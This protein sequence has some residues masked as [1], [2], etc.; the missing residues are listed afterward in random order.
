MLN[1]QQRI[2]LT[3]VSPF[4]GRV[5]EQQPEAIQTADDGM[6]QLCAPQNYRQ[7]IDERL[8]SVDDENRAQQELRLQRN[9]WFAALAAADLLGQLTLQQM[10]AHLTAA[11]DAFISASLAWLYPRFTSRHGTPLNADGQEQQLLVI[12]MGK[13]GGG[14]LNF[15]SDIDLIF[16][17][18]EQGETDHSRKPI[19]NGVF[20]TRLGQ[21]LVGLL[22]APTG[23][24]RVFRVDL[25]LRPFGQS[26]PLVA[27][28][29]ALEYYYQEQGRD[30]E[31]YAMVKARMIGA[32][33]AWQEELRSLLRPFVYRRYIDFSAIDAL[34]KMKSLITQETRRQGVRNNI[35]LGPGGI[36]E[37]EFIAQAFQL[38]RGGQERQ[39]QTQS[40][41][42]AY[43]AIRDLNLLAPAAVTELLSCYEH[44]RK[45]EHVLQQINDEQTQTLPDDKE[46]QQ[47]I[48]RVFDQ[49]WEQITADIATSMNKV[50]GHFKMVIGD[51]E[52]D[53]EEAGPLQL[54]WQDMV[55]DETALS[56][57]QDTG[58]GK[59]TA[60]MIW[61]QVNQLR[62]EVRKR[63]SGPRGR[64]AMARLVPL[65]L[66]R[67]I[68]FEDAEF[69]LERVLNVLRKIMSRTAYVELLVENQ[70]AREQLLK[71]CRASSWLTDQLANYPL[72]LDELIDPAHLYQLPEF[73]EYPRLLEEYL[74]RIPEQEVDLEAQ[75]NAL[76]QARQALQLK[77][78]AADISGALPLMKV[79]DHLS[80]LAEAMIGHVV[81]LAW[82]QL[83]EKHGVPPGCS[84]DDNG[85]AVMAY[86]K[87]GGL[88][89]GYGSD[90]DLVFLTN[91]PYE[92]ET[93]GQ[94]PI[95]IQQFYLRLAQ[96]ILH[97]FTT[98][99]MIGVLYEVDMRLR[100][101]GK[102]GLLVT[103]VD[104]FE[105]YLK[106]DAWT[107]ELQ[108]LVRAR[109]VYGNKELQQQ[110]TT[111]RQQHLQRHRD[112]RELQEQVVSM[113]AKMREHLH[114][115]VR[116]QE[117]DT[118]QGV[119]GI[120]DI[121]FLVQYLVLAY[122]SEYPELT[123]YTDNIRILETAGSHGLLSD[124]Q[125]SGLIS[126]Y[127]EQRGVLHQLALD[128]K[129]PVTRQD[130]SQARTAV[131]S[132]WKHCFN[133]DIN[134][135]PRGSDGS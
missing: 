86:G 82:F 13:L 31:R 35:K 60:N 91:T 69:V 66:G 26:G 83:A 125:V 23:D 99:T 49:P 103:Q 98:R 37:I 95:E 92:G 38:I 25:R 59:N 107:W 43:A 130:L 114:N 62:Q 51:P 53:D 90:L 18:P 84:V 45:V 7:R 50:H 71:L 93:D 108:A 55:E 79:S 39:L 61:Q 119:G 67:I 96:R 88:E 52:Q 127:I 6:I 123:R 118:K 126:A 2:F 1:D 9:A 104:T 27:S 85:L 116:E 11:A 42:L 106:E 73:A 34:R 56:V 47:R 131:I 120:T 3:E 15:S 109:P 33:A 94:K 115:A 124:E 10:L 129:G 68:Q 58:V 134:Q 101:S 128:K 29:S 122:S 81:R 65:L 133:L 110:L 105:Q 97:I 54:L 46:T 72:L 113:R 20:F 5:L 111:M 32:E 40:L 112:Q 57:L 30:W 121:E 12:G 24:G 89:L 16:C 41:Y 76:R 4:I 63:G 36:R 78:A 102:S 44:L 75:M 135:D 21:A 87:L 74:L 64:K 77:V 22:D 132:A 80:Y 70:G 28:M 19:E 100:P 14:E 117:F 8:A 17:Y 48:S